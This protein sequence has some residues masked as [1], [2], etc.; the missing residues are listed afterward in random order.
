[1][2]TCVHI[3][4]KKQL[5][6]Y[7]CMQLAGLKRAVRAGTWETRL[8]RLH[9]HVQEH[10]GRWMSFD[11]KIQIPFCICPSFSSLC[12][13]WSAG[14]LP[15]SGDFF[16]APLGRAPEEGSPQL[17]AREPNIPTYR[18]WYCLEWDTVWLRNVTSCSFPFRKVHK[19]RCKMLQGLPVHS[20][21]AG[22]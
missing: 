15:F 14:C 13:E 3:V 18:I 8:Q 17:T 4:K 20:K 12:V 22:T 9:K 6:A 5:E 11:W 7:R 1:M 19:Q 16:D 10:H 2:Y 21:S